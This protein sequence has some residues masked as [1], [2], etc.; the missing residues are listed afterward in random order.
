MVK[1]G[2]SIPIDLYEKLLAI[3]NRIGSK[4]RSKLIQIAL[5]D[6]VINRSLELKQ[7]I[8]II[9]VIG[10]YYKHGRK[11]IDEELVDIQ[12]DFIDVIV[13]TQHIHVSKENCAEF[14]VVRGDSQRIS[15]LLKTLYSLDIL[16]INH[17]LIPI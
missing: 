1:V 12:H 4:N 14:I 5:R 10:I 3:A 7:G 2:V 8:N 15:E 9:G 17:I 16:Y 13:S 6:F 11:H